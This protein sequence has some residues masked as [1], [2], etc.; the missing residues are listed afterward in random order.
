MPRTDEIHP[1]RVLVV[2]LA[3]LGDLLV[4]EP[5]LRSL[6]TA[7]PDARI[8]VLVAPGSV[9]LARLLGHD[10]TV[11]AFPKSAFDSL[12]R[13]MHPRA[14]ARA[15][16]LAMSLRQARYEIVVILHHLTTRAGAMKFRALARATRARSIIG[17]DNGRGQFLTASALDRGFGARHEAEYMLDVAIAAGGSLVDAAPQFDRR[18]AV[19]P[20]GLPARFAAIFPVTGA[21]SSARTWPPERYA[22]VAASLARSGTPVVV[23]GA[24][25]AHDAAH[26]IRHACP[27]ALDLTGNTTLTQLAGVVGRADVVIGGDSFVG[28]LAA[29]LGRPVVSVFGPSNS[30][31]WRPFPGASETRRVVVRSGLPCEP[32]LYTG[33]SLGRP[34]GCPDRTCLGMVTAG[35]VVAATNAAMEAA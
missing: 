9:E 23:V 5:A 34:A 29:A 11:L 31:A 20:P 17:L 10:L 6:R 24:D 3:D 35:S 27:E 21:Y 18:Q 12:P 26:T 16:G 2:K 32:C 8:D 19:E 30:D 13:A 33:Y 25:D 14:V 15:A 4:C 7:F 1:G 28:H 22:S